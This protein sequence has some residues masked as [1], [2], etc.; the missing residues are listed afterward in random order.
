M[1]LEGKDLFWKYLDFVIYFYYLYS[2]LN[3]LT[4]ISRYNTSFLIFIHLFVNIVQ[5]CINILLYR[6]PKIYK[7]FRLN[8]MNNHL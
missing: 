6:D 3:I 8:Y 2:S 4:K 1:P 5:I 7:N